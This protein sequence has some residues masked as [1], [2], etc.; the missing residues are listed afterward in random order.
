MKN[1]SQTTDSISRK[2]AFLLPALPATVATAAFAHGHGAVGAGLLS[3]VIVAAIAI[4]AW[5]GNGLLKSLNASSRAE[6]RSQH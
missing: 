2:A 3:L 4:G 1:L 5:L 6:A